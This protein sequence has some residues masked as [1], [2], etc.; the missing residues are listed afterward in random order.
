MA[1]ACHVKLNENFRDSVLI[2]FAGAEPCA[3]AE[4]SQNDFGGLIESHT[5]P[6]PHAVLGTLKR[7]PTTNS[8]WTQRQCRERCN[9]LHPE[10]KK[11]HMD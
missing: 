8:G 10:I 6:Q 9:V 5:L 1:K 4:C 11:R 7:I 3:F 2:V